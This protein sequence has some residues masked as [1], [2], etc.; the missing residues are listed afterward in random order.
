MATRK[1]K[2]PAITDLRVVQHFQIQ[3]DENGNESYTNVGWELQ[4]QR[5]TD[6]WEKL[7]VESV[8]LPE[9]VGNG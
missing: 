7:D 6:E 1:T 3:R 8:V 9:V 4:L 2:I 5:G